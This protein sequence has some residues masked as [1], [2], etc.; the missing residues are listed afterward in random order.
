L[1]Q[2]HLKEKYLVPQG[3][4]AAAIESA[5]VANSQSA[6]PGHSADRS[7]TFELH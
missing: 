1:K 2:S 5:L 3:L 6:A 7:S 4:I